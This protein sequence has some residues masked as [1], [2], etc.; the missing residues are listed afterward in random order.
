MKTGPSFYSRSVCMHALNLHCYEAKLPSLKLKTQTE[1]LLGSLLLD[2]AL[3]V[4]STLGVQKPT[5]ENLKVVW[6]EF[7]TLSLSVFVLNV[8][9]WHRQ[10]CPRVE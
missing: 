10:E 5:G 4:F 3:S 1:Q 2:I 6:A 9:V 8:I 7:S